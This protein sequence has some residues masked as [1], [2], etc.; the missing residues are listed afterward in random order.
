MFSEQENGGK[1]FFIDGTGAWGNPTPGNVAY[2]ASKRAL[3]QLKVRSPSIQLPL[4]TKFFSPKQPPCV[5]LE[6]LPPVQDSYFV[7]LA[8]ITCIYWAVGLV[9][10]LVIL[11]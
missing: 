6:L 9:A 8:S 2:G 5:C 7:L 3:T 1:V 11:C 10:S 4:T